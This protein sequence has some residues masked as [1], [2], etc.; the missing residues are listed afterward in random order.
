[1]SVIIVG[2]KKE[3]A[4]PFY[5]YEHIS[6]SNYGEGIDNYWCSGCVV[7]YEQYDQYSSERFA[8]C[9]AEGVVSYEVLAVVDIGSRYQERVI[10]KVEKLDPDG[11]KYGKATIKTLTKKM[12]IKHINSHTPFNLDYDIDIDLRYE[13]IQKLK[14]KKEVF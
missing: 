1:M 6:A 5:S 4:W 10:V 8:S 9:N 13:E 3:M 2:D 12:Y 11:E 7:W 14:N